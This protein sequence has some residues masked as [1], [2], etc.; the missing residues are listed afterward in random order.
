MKQSTPVTTTKQSVCNT[1]KRKSGE[2]DAKNYDENLL[3]WCTSLRNI[4]HYPFWAATESLVNQETE[5]SFQHLNSTEN[6]LKFIPIA[7]FPSS[8]FSF[9]CFLHFPLI[10]QLLETWISFRNW[11]RMFVAVLIFK[12][13]HAKTIFWSK[14][15]FYSCIKYQLM[16]NVKQTQKYIQ[17]MGENSFS[18]GHPSHNNRKYS[19]SQVDSRW[20][21]TTTS[22]SFKDSLNPHW[23]LDFVWRCV[24]VCCAGTKKIF[25]KMEWNRN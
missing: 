12:F 11:R 2:A 25:G 17:E 7:F 1:Y 9:L 24:S 22:K 10:L 23:K 15:S 16:E 13:S 5:Q 3:I 8:F 4:L 18:S 6:Y 14:S 21:A 20:C 19:G